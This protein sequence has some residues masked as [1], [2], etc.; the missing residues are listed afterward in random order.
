MIIRF[1]IILILGLFFFTSNPVYSKENSNQTLEK[2][3]NKISNKFSKTYCNTMQFG[4]S[5]EGALEFAIGE[6]NKEFK[7]NKL[8]DFIDYSQLK[9]N[10]VNNLENNCLVYDFPLN[11][12]DKLKFD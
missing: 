3:I 10:I 6:T 11:K 7:K 1:L 8:N 12:L 2:Y 9:N 4:I 5:S